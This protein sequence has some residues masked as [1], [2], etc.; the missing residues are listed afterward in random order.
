MSGSG[1]VDPF[2]D[3]SETSKDHD[4]VPECEFRESKASILMHKTF[5]IPF[6]IHSYCHKLDRIPLLAKLNAD[7]VGQV[8]ISAFMFLIQQT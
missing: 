1:Y 4:P 8:V 7:A 3:G 5:D 6:M 2:A